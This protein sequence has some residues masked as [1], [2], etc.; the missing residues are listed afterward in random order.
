MFPDLTGTF[1]AP[2]PVAIFVS[3]LS[4]AAN[5]RAAGPRC[6]PKAMHDA[7]ASA[8]AAGQAVAPARRHDRGKPL[9]AEITHR[10][11]AQKFRDHG[12]DAAPNGRGPLGSVGL[13]GVSMT[14]ISHSYAL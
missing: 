14:V 10:I 4:G 2:E 6:R 11:S 5:S 8:Y 13:C 3:D 7:P 12:Q 1:S 9:I